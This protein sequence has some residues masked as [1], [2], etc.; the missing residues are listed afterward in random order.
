M[1]N[2]EKSIKILFKVDDLI[3]ITPQVIRLDTIAKQYSIKL[4]WGIVGSS[5]LIPKLQNCISFVRYI[6]W[7]KKAHKSGIYEF[8]N[9]GF[10]HSNAPI[11]FYDQPCCEQVKSI[12][13][14]QCLIKALLG[15]E[16]ITF[17]AP[18]NKKDVATVEALN[19][20]PEIKLW[21]YGNSYFNHWQTYKN[22]IINRAVELENTVGVPCLERL[23]R[24]FEKKEKNHDFFSLQIHPNMW[25][26]SEF[27]E[28]IRCLEY[29]K[30]KKC[31]Y[32][33]PRDLLA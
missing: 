30:E 18:E 29:L 8:W 4:A 21:F 11:E 16:C 23:K 28:F 14:T 17:G 26:N 5:L 31:T 12:A 32:I 2:K 15:F 19:N 7:I 24:D 20:F 9:H 1:E 6:Y 10:T 33:L 3:K 27:E 13:Y 22:T 25:N